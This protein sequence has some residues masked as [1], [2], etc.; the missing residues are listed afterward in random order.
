MQ[1]LYAATS[2]LAIFAP[3]VGPNETFGAPNTLYQG[4][5][6]LCYNATIREK[7]WCV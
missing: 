4:C 1:G 2:A 7:F 5:G 3:N 6:S